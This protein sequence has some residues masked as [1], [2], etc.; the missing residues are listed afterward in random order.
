L[1]KLDHGRAASRELSRESDRPGD[2]C[3]ETTLEDVERILNPEA[4]RC[5]RCPSLFSTTGDEV[6]PRP[7]RLCPACRLDVEEE[8]AI[9]GLPTT[10]LD[11]RLTKALADIAQ[12]EARVVRAEQRDS[13]GGRRRAMRLRDR[14]NRIRNDL[15]REASM[16]EAA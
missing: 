10:L 12:I 3:V 9:N 6:R 5:Q 14:I 1:T 7:I 2:G 15:H 4:R 13:S 11:D 16:R 8:C